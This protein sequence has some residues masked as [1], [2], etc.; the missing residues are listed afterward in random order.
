M[1]GWV[2][3]GGWLVRQ[4]SG[5]TY[6]LAEKV[7]TNDGLVKLNSDKQALLFTHSVK[8]Q[9]LETT[10]AVPGLILPLLYCCTP[11]QSGC[12]AGGATGPAAWAAR[13]PNSPQITEYPVCSA[14]CT[15]MQCLLGSSHSI[16]RLSRAGELGASRGLRGNIQICHHC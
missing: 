7:K 12:F 11:L 6:V 15:T 14:G 13:L 2:V 16:S 10:A 1:V 4:L 3:N 5:E 8:P 9:K